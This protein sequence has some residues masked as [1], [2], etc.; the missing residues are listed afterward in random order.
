VPQ[1]CFSRTFFAHAREWC[2][3][4]EVDFMNWIMQMIR[5]C[6][7]KVRTARWVLVSI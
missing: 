5:N 4:V 3:S 7:L 6:N 1:D 2:L